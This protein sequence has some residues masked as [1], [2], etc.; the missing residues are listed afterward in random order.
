[1]MTKSFYR[2]INDVV[3]NSQVKPK[4]VAQKEYNKAKARGQTA[5]QVKQR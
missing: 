1:M 5:G 2:T 4:A 3:Y